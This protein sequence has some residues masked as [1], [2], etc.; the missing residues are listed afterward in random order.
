VDRRE[1]APP[2]GLQRPPPHRTSWA[3]P[4]TGASRS[5]AS[6]QLEVLLR[7][8]PDVGHEQ[9]ARLHTKAGPP[10]RP[11]PRWNDSIDL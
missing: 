9:V 4:R 8:P 11:E 2:I 3:D 5:Q 7:Q 1:V 10:L 6:Q